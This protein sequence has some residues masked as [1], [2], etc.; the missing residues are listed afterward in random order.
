MDF[1]VINPELDTPLN[2]LM[3]FFLL[4]LAIFAPIYVSNQDKKINKENK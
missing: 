2:L 1:L 3:A 4:L